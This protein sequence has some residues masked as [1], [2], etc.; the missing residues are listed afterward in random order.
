VLNMLLTLFVFSAKEALRT[1]KNRTV[2]GGDEMIKR[3]SW[4]HAQP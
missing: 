3:M 2:D 1:D 4:M